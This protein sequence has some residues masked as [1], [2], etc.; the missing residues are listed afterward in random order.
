MVSCVEPQFR[1]V[2][3]GYERRHVGARFEA[4]TSNRGC[5][6]AEH[7]RTGRASLG[8][9]SEPGDL[10]LF[11]R[12]PGEGGGVPDN[13]RFNLVEFNIITDTCRTT[14][15]GGAI[16]MLG[17]GDPA[18]AR[19]PSPKCSHW[20]QSIAH[21]SLDPALRN[22]A[23]SCHVYYATHERT[24]GK[25]CCPPWVRRR[26]RLRWEART[27][28]RNVHWTAF[29]RSR[30]HSGVCAHQPLSPAAGWHPQL[31]TRGALAHLRIA[32]VFCMSCACAHRSCFCL[33]A[34][35]RRTAPRPGGT[36]PTRFVSTTSATQWAPPRA[37]A[38][39]PT[40]VAN[41]TNGSAVF[42]FT[43]V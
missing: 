17:S 24:L 34:H 1:A 42:R 30:V 21:G 28:L 38:R 22:S 18:T 40:R 4:P 33:R 15:D 2:S 25:A 23:S 27:V 13:S 16:E 7:R 32:H 31:A 37:T 39:C 35:A 10:S 9:C 19:L 36:R 29:T 12:A 8:M 11:A 3:D 20:F 5:S 14:S 41:E 6:A 43:R 26:P